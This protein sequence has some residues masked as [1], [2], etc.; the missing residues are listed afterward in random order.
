MN[1]NP[2]DHESR[3][4]RYLIEGTENKKLA[5]RHTPAHGMFCCTFEDAS[6]CLTKRHLAS[7]AP[8]IR[9]SATDTMANPNLW[10]LLVEGTLKIVQG[11]PRVTGV[12]MYMTLR[13][14]E[15]ISLESEEVTKL[16]KLLEVEKQQDVFDPVTEES[17]HFG[18]RSILFQELCSKWESNNG[19]T[20]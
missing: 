3:F 10:W 14:G 12:V 8:D 11:I 6:I 19:T 4:V 7:K 17:T 13:V 15:V 5:W 16:H 20:E 2:E 1:K 18:G 9:T